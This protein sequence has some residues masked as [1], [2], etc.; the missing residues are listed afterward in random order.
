M[1]SPSPLPLSEGEPFHW[2]ANGLLCAPLCSPRPAVRELRCSVRMHVYKLCK[3]LSPAGFERIA[4]FG[5]C[6]DGQGRQSGWLTVNK[7]YSAAQ[8]AAACAGY[9]FFTVANRDQNCK[10]ADVC[11][12]VGDGHTAYR[13]TGGMSLKIFEEICC[14]TIDHPPTLTDQLTKLNFIYMY[15]YS[16]PQ[17]DKVPTHTPAHTLSLLSVSLSL[18]FSVFLCLSLSFSLSPCLLP[19]LCLLRVQLHRIHCSY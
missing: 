6:R 17:H 15:V 13:F 1:P 11:E 16:L 10:C 4:G 19:P 5:G 7:P 8:C 2:L 18:C 14:S 3:L 12:N 9:K